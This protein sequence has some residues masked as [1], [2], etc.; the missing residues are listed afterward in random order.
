ML[1]TKNPGVGSVLS[2]ITEPPLTKR[3]LDSLNPISQLGGETIPF[4]GER[5]VYFWDT[6]GSCYHSLFLIFT[7]PLPLSVE[8]RL[9]PKKQAALKSVVT[10]R[11]IDDG[12]QVHRRERVQQE[13]LKKAQERP[14]GGI[15]RQL[16]RLGHQRG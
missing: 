3:R 10:Y 2:V 12:G 15:P 16:D 5:A 11:T 14:Q 1:Q 8:N 4:Q 6:V 13:E 9:L 7:K